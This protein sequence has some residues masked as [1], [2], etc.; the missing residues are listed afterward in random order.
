ML[1]L[2]LGIH[3][4]GLYLNTCLSLNCIKL[5][6]TKCYYAKDF[7]EYVRIRLKV[8]SGRQE[9]RKS[10]VNVICASYSVLFLILKKLRD[11]PV[12]IRSCYLCTQIALTTRSGSI[13]SNSVIAG[14]KPEQC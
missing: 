9:R 4:I 1:N 13:Y 11:R 7:N 6:L 2:D 5:S 14:I 8:C 10:Q 3:A 12:I